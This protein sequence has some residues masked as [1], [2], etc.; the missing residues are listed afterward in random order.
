VCSSVILP[1]FNQ[2]LNSYRLTVAEHLR[3]FCML[4]GMENDLVE[5][6]ITRLIASLGLESKRDAKSRTLSG[7]MKR[8]LSVLIAF[9]ANSK[10]CIS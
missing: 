2:C 7:G 5:P 6:E 8:K 1:Q 4:K 10:V 3:F 9:C